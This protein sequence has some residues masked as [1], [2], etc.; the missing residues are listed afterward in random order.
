MDSLGGEWVRRASFSAEHGLAG[1]SRLRGLVRNTLD[2]FSADAV[3]TIELLV[4]E[5]FANALLHARSSPQI[6]IDVFKDDA[7][8]RVAV[9]DRSHIAPHIGNRSIT[10][11]G[12]RGMQ[13]VH[14]L[15]SEWGWDLTPDGKRVWFVV[16]DPA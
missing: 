15:S 10:A 5:L 16:D 7:A 3:A 12:G 6:Q 1:A 14:A 11:E 13:L 9:N 2:E 4:T 8:V